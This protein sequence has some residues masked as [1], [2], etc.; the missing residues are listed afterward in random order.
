MKGIVLAGGTATRLYPISYTVSKQLLPIYDRQM[1]FYP[2]NTLVRAGIKDILVIVNPRDAGQYLSLLGPMFDSTDIKIT[3]KV[4]TE[5]RGLADAFILGE[6]FIGDDAVAM[7]LGD[8]IFEGNFLGHVES[9]DSGCR[10][11]V[12]K[13]RQPGKYGVACMDGDGSITGIVEKPKI[14][15]SDYAVLG[16]YIF[17]N[18]VSLLSKLLEPSQ[19]QEL[20]VVDLLVKYLHKGELDHV[21][22]DSAW[23]DAG[24]FNDWLDANNWVRDHRLEF[25]DSVESVIRRSRMCGST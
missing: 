6:S 15:M 22:V 25:D 1:I 7:I 3:F 17:D 10:I 14:H 2:L 13:V 23:F 20:E 24:T 9:F 21:I 18:K 19:R 16:F 5:P 8:N 4:Q 11:F 12:K